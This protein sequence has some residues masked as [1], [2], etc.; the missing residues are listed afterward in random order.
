MLRSLQAMDMQPPESIALVGFDDFETAELMRPGITV[1][2]QPSELLGR[3]AAEVLFERLA[4]GG[5]PK[6]GKRTILPVEL[7]VRGSCGAKIPA[8]SK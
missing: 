7:V 4:A 3:T 2:R 8:S 6:V 1:V 5:P